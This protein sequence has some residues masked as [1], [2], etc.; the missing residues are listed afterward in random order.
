VASSDP[1]A[2]APEDKFADEV[3]AIVRE[4]TGAHAT[5]MARFEL[6]VTDAAASQVTTLQLRD[7]LGRGFQGRAAR[8]EPSASAV[9]SS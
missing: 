5:K 7:H 1:A 8:S 9:S 2:S 3:V 6:E 4:L